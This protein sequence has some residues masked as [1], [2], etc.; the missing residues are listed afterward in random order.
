MQTRWPDIPKAFQNHVSSP[1]LEMS[2]FLRG[3]TSSHKRL[4]LHKGCY[5]VLGL[6]TNLASSPTAYAQLQGQSCIQGIAGGGVGKERKEGVQD[7][8]DKALP[9]LRT[10][11]CPPTLHIANPQ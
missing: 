4:S 9:K 10:R 7:R 1:T 8:Q 11:V 3:I 6:I 5:S 2:T